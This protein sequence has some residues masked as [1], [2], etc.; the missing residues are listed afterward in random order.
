M[1]PAPP[2]GWEG[3]GGR[4][5]GG[6]VITGMSTELTGPGGTESEWIRMRGEGTVL[7]FHGKLLDDSCPGG[8]TERV[9]Q[10]ADSRSGGFTPKF[11]KPRLVGFA[12]VRPGGQ[13][14]VDRVQ[15]V[16]HLLE[17][18]PELLL[19]GGLNEDVEG[20]AR[21]NVSANA[22]KADARTSSLDVLDV[23]PVGTEDL[24]FE[25][26]AEECSLS[27]KLCV[28][29]AGF[30][31]ASDLDPT[32]E[33]GE[34]GSRRH[35][36]VRLEIQGN[37]QELLTVFFSEHAQ[38]GEDGTCEESQG[39]LRVIA[40]FVEG[41]GVELR[42][43]IGQAVGGKQFLRRVVRPCELREGFEQRRDANV[44]SFF[45]R[46][47]LLRRS[48]RA[49]QRLDAVAAPLRGSVGREKIGRGDLGGPAPAARHGW[50]EGTWI[51]RVERFE[52]RSADITGVIRSM[53]RKMNS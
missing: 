45:R 29:D 17:C 53:P 14:L 28:I 44:V 27:H 43:V 24:V 18:S 38:A 10:V 41:G 22:S 51:C 48:L 35:L 13:V 36:V 7:V 39:A 42:G 3:R 1:S 25:R 15:E 8:E 40:L 37:L 34:K 4:R 11:S 9:K 2:L 50:E 46:S 6:H 31:F 20:R 33:D 12:S 19:A 49:A 52:P 30:G 32:C 23:S 21:S 26:E 16:V 5:G 47:G